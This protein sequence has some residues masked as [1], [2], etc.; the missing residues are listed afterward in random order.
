MC[1]FGY[2][3]VTECTLQLRTT[4]L[5]ADGL[6]MISLNGPYIIPLGQVIIFVLNVTFSMWDSNMCRLS[7]SLDRCRLSESVWQRE[8]GLAYVG[9]QQCAPLHA[10]TFILA[11]PYAPELPA[12]GQWGLSAQQALHL[13]RSVCHSVVFLT[14]ATGLWQKF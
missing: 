4:L 7:L 12:A 8:P 1:C 5:E 10:L 14:K 6:W 3:T 13:P 2:N 9:A 11:L